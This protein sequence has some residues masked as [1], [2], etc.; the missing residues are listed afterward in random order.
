MK[1]GFCRIIKVKV[2]SDVSIFARKRNRLLLLSNNHDALSRFVVGLKKLR[3]FD[4]YKGKGIFEYSNFDGIK[5]K[6]GKQQQ[7]Y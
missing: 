6:V 5:L 4:L 1:L 3:K 7:F 2:P